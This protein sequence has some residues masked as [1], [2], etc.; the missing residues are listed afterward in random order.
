MHE[1][2]NNTTNDLYTKLPE[3]QS[4]GTLQNI[5]IDTKIGAGSFGTILS[6]VK[7]IINRRSLQRNVEWCHSCGTKETQ[8]S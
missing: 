3:K 7:L 8:V 6:L 5:V 1:M 4:I 2:A